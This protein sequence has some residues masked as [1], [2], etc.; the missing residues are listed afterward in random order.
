MIMHM[1]GVRY[2]EVVGF[3]NNHCR[4]HTLKCM[5]T[6]EDNGYLGVCIQLPAETFELIFSH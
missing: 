3:K 2:T 4:P 5:L 1:Q 6:L